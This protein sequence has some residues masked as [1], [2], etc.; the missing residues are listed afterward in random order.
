MAATAETEVTEATEETEAEEETMAR[1]A[2]EG[3][4]S[5]RTAQRGRTTT[6]RL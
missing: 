2:E 4:A 5:L 3:E 1:E 6:R